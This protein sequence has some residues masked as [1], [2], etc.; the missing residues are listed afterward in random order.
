MEAEPG[1]LIFKGVRPGVTHAQVEAAV[2]GPGGEGVVALLDSAP[3]V[4]GDCHNLPSGTV[5][6]LGA[7]V[8]VAEVQTRATRPSGCT[9]GRPSTGAVGAGCM[10]SRRWR[11]LISGR[12]EACG[13]CT[14]GLVCNAPGDDG[15]LHGG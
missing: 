11:A 1:G 5:H 7:G 8:L 2:Q 12:R 10:W 9:T 14:A 6:T 13:A 3:A 15:V 4:V